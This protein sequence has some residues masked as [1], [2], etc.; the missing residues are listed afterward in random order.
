MESRVIATVV[1][2]PVN[3]ML[4]GSIMRSRVTPVVVGLF[5]F[6]DGTLAGCIVE[7]RVIAVV[8]QSTIVLVA[9]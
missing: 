3:S 7:W 8:G 9:G 1:G 2:Q 5:F 4:A 6:C